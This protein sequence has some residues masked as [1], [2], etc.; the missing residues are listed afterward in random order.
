MVVLAALEAAIAQ[1][2]P[3]NTLEAVHDAAVRTITA[4]LVEIG[5]LQ[6]DVEELIT[7][8]AYRRFFMHAT[9]H[10]VGLDVHDRGRYRVD[11]ASRPLELG[12]VLSVEPGIYIAEPASSVVGEDVYE[13]IG[14]RIEDTV[15]VTPDGCEV[16]T[17]AAPKDPD[18]V[19]ALIAS[20]HD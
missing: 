6:G 5:L 15:L 3:G 20:A 13:S 17:S 10:W 7:T 18:A 14:V 9:S 1:V 12:M 16:L 11:G 19:E 2:R 4:G 8:A